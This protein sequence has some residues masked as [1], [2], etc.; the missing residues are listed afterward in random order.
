MEFINNHWRKC[1]ECEE[2][3]RGFIEFTNPRGGFVA[4]CYDCINE[5]QLRERST[6]TMLHKIVGAGMYP[7]VGYDEGG[8][9]AW[10]FVDKP[11][12]GVNIAPYEKVQGS[13][14][15]QDALIDLCGL[16]WASGKLAS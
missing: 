8:W 7:G 16:L 2:L 11:V 15:P 5:A 6:V 9:E 10:V 14:S 1:D 13:L 12:E 4:V 3:C